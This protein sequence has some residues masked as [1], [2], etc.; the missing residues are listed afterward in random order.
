MPH[1]GR[2]ETAGVATGAPVG[3]GRIQGRAGSAGWIRHVTRVSGAGGDS[4]GVGFGLLPGS[5]RGKLRRM[6][7]GIPA[8]SI[9]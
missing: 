4:L 2:G 9:P 5:W 7:R 6:A 3:F 1:R 8:T